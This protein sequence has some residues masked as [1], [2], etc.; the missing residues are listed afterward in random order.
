MTHFEKIQTDMYEA[1]KS[2]EKE[3]ANTLRSVI[4][5]LKDKQIEKR[6][7]LTKEEEIKVL[8]TLVKQRKE[9]IDLYQK[10]GRNELAEIE[11][12]EM[13]IIN[14]YLPTM[15]DEDDVK[16]IVQSVIKDTGASSMADMGKVMPEIMKLGKGL[17]DGKTAQRLVS[18]QL[19]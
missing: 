4:S 7:T 11:S 12:K 6:D 2:G 10:G 5:K 9:S 19:G 1:M 16:K 8:Q 15:M 18:E 17:I 14:S 13:D 3:K